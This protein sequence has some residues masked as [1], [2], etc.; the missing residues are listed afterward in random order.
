MSIEPLVPRGAGRRQRD[1]ATLVA[2]ISLGK[3]PWQSMSVFAPNDLGIPTVELR[4][5]EIADS[6]FLLPDAAEALGKALIA[7]A[8]RARGA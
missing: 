1:A 8:A 7:A 3:Q 5:A 4:Y 6:V 2:K